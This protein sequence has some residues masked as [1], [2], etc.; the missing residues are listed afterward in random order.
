[1]KMPNGY[2]SIVNLGKKRRKPF[3]VRVTVGYEEKGIING[4]MQYRQN[5]NIS[6]IL[7][8]AKRL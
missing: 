8:S 1:M 6:V 2:G 3:A 5:I 7:K 4:V